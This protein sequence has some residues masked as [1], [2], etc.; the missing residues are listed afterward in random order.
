MSGECF[1]MV[2]ADTILRSADGQEFRV[3]KSMLSI[4]S[5]IFRDMFTF[6]QPHSPEPSSILVV[7]MYDAGTCST[8][9]SNISTG[10]EAGRRG[11]RA[12]GSFDAFNGKGLVW[13]AGEGVCGVQGVLQ[14]HPKNSRWA[15][16]LRLSWRVV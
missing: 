7:E 16:S 11:P 9:F 14:G 15:R 2:D 12:V 1:G 8:C 4:T 13:R 5:P 10:T 3:H 6:L